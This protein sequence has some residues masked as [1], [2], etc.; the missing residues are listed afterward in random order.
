MMDSG[1]K[2]KCMGGAN[3]IMKAA[4]LHI[5][6]NGRMTSFMAMVKYIMIILLFWRGALIIPILIYLM[7]TGSFMKEC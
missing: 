7:I 3:S 4:S 1:K 2:I 6:V 5:R